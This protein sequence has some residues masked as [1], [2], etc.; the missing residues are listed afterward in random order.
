MKSRCPQT[1]TS[2]SIFYWYANCANSTF[3]I[4]VWMTM[5]RTYTIALCHTIMTKTKRI[6]TVSFRSWKFV[7]WIWWL[8]FSPVQYSP[9]TP[10]P[11]GKESRSNIYSQQCINSTQNGFH[12][13]LWYCIS[14]CSA[15]TYTGH[16]NKQYCSFAAFCKSKDTVRGFLCTDLHLTAGLL[17]AGCLFTLRW[18]EL[19]LWTS[20]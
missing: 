5:A 19:F 7:I 18:T 20:W 2:S 15:K 13:T 8:G 4:K 11:I 3:P 17:S 9:K 16:T 14:M 1:A 6:V 12:H 10:T